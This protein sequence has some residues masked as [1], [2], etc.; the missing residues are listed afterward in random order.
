[1][2]HA[3]IR[4]IIIKASRK[5]ISSLLPAIAG[6]NW[7][8]RP[9]KIALLSRWYWEEDRRQGGSGGGMVREVAEAVAALGHEVVVLSQSSG[10]DALEKAH[11][12]AL[13]VWLS[14]RE[15]RRDFLTGLRDK[16]AKQIYRHR[17]VCTDA[18]ALR[19]FLARR[20]PFDVL[21]AQCEEPDGLVAAIAARQ[22]VP[23]PPLLTQIHALRYRFDGGRPVF[24]EKPAL[25][26]AFRQA[27]RIIANSQLAANSL[28][29][30]A[31]PGL[32]ME[33]LPAKV[34]VVYPNL[35]LEFL[36]AAG[37]TSG[38]ASE[39]GRVLFFGALNE[40]KGALVFMEALLKTTAAPNGAR[41][42]IAGGFTE[43]NPL[44]TRRWEE[45]VAAA[46]ERLAPGQLEL[47]GKIPSAEA[48]REIQR[49][50]L[51]VL[52]SLFDEFSRALV[53]TLILGRPVVTTDHVGAAP[54]V[55][56]HECGLVVPAGD[57]EALARAI[58]LALSPNAIYAEN[59]R[60]VGHRLLHEFS[61]GAIARQIA[62]HLSEIALPSHP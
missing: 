23:L 57:A 32:P 38:P 45:S 28:L 27:T 19:D 17:K 46:R 41:F 22:G 34:S 14:P 3:I 4:K 18:L 13:E 55:E 20:G 44:F 35:Q 10:V 36:R 53:E 58:D 26:L 21:W 56:A 59:A 39:P 52:P 48:I 31:G 37:E 43:N 49:A 12:G 60:R 62:Q 9:L 42:V 29:H 1:L 30:Y 5:E 16:L 11:I 54:L 24:N 25:S 2:V 7:G 33:Q 8:M 51:V 15:K 61:P 47:T 40:K 50:A 6:Y